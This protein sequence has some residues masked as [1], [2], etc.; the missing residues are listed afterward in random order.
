MSA[1]HLKIALHQDA[2][3]PLQ[4][5]LEVAAGEL[6]ALVGPSG[7]G[8]TTVLR[9]VAGLYPP[10]AGRISCDGQIWLDS[11]AGIHVP[12]Q[13]RRVGI[14]FQDYALFP[15]L[16]AL[17]NLTLAM[18]SGSRVQRRERARDLL[19]R[20]H[21]EGLEQRRP[22]ELSGGQQQRV[23]VARALAR[24]P[25][26]LLLD[27]PF[28]AVDM[29]TRRRLQRELALLRQSLD[30]PIILVTHDLDE[31]V[32]LADRICLLDRGSAVQTDTPERL[33][34]HPRSARVARLLGLSNTFSGRIVR[35]GGEERLSWGRHRLTLGRPS[36]LADGAEV[37]WYIPQ[38]DIVL[39]RAD[40]PSRGER[41][42][43]VAATVEEVAA[44]GAQ[45]SV[46]LREESSGDRLKLS[47]P[48]HAARRNGLQP[49]AQVLV[50]LLAE[51]IH[52]MP[53]AQSEAGN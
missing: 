25:R 16:S 32:T 27:E 11:P 2:P 10:R 44:L 41:E 26:V 4:V 49:G 18:D 30:I 37:A 14:V 21:L 43:P 42:N 7:S 20:V 45:A 29:V 13:A 47:I 17:E 12:P 48:T 34:R 1:N 51:A 38:S 50:S 31:A 35:S 33:F 24:D 39:Q 19:A 40:R 3:I 22:H 23:A 6:V 15:H 36:G 46:T 53:A 52:L 5:D 28:S 8:K 9:L